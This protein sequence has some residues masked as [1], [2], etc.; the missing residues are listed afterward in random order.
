M[1]GFCEFLLGTVLEGIFGLKV[2]N[3]KAKTWVKTL[4][5]FLF[6]ESLAALFLWMSF[7]SPAAEPGRDLTIRVISVALGIG[8]LIAVVRGHRR[9]WKQ[10]I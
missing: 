1:D 5:F 4:V 7:A 10:D 3:P 9:D 8:C 2:K 6:S